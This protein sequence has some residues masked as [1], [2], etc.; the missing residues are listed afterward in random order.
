MQEQE[1]GKVSGHD[2]RSRSGNLCT[3]T[4]PEGVL[5]VLPCPLVRSRSSLA[6]EQE[7]GRDQEQEAQAQGE[8]GQGGRFF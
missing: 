1:Q 4:P 6:Q 7:P 8:P 5:L 2:R 3:I